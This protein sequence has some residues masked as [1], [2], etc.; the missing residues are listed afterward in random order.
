MADMQEIKAKKAPQIIDDDKNTKLHY[1]AALGEEEKLVKQLETVQKVDVENYLGWTPLMMACKNGHLNVVN[2]LLHHRADASKKNRF[3]MSVFLVSVASGNLD[4]V[5]VI[6]QHLLRGGVSRQ[7]MQYILSPIAVSILF[8]HQHILK[9]LVEQ[10]FNLNSPTPVTAITPLMFAS[11]MENNEAIKLLIAR[12]AD[13]TERNCI[14]ITA[15][16]ITQLKNRTDNTQLTQGTQMVP[17]MTVLKSPY[18]QSLQQPV[19]YIMVSPQPTF[20]QVPVNQFLMRKSSNMI[21]PS[22]NY[23]YNAP[24]VTPISPVHFV[25]QQQ[26]FFPPDFSPS[27]Y[28]TGSPIT[29]MYNTSNDFLNARMNLSNAYLS[30]LAQTNFPSPCV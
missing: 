11:A 24:N 17:P 7:S 5:H 9:Y 14:G 19:P 30:P 21:S 26:V 3:R 13:V 6:L 22:P 15:H 12:G 1:Y 28:Y 20:I 25:A 29:N 27:Q 18:V 10:N 8:C 2:L 4:V 23:F 16:G